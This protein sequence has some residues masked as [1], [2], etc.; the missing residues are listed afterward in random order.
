MSIRDFLAATWR[1]RDVKAKSWH[2]MI[3]KL[4]KATR[5]K[6]YNDMAEARNRGEENTAPRP[7]MPGE[8]MCEIDG[9]IANLPDAPKK[10]KGAI[11]QCE[12]PV[13]HVTYSVED[14]WPHHYCA[15]HQHAD[16]ILEE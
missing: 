12:K 5:E 6:I 9:C 15:D 14:G 3:A 10:K 13:T 1:M 8:P 2:E 4:P 16:K 11:I 7:L